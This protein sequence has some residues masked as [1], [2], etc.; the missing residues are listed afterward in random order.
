MDGLGGTAAPRRPSRPRR[1]ARGGSGSPRPRGSRAPR[2]RPASAPRPPRAEP[3]DGPAVS[4]RSWASPIRGESVQGG[5]SR[6]SKRL[7]RRLTV[8]TALLV[9]VLPFAAGAWAVAGSEAARTRS[10]AEAALQDTLRQAATDYRLVLARAARRSQALASSRR[11]QRAFERRDRRALRRLSRPNVRLELGAMLPPVRAATASRSTRIVVGKRRIGTVIVSV[12]FD[13]RLLARLEQAESRPSRELAFAH[14]RRLLLPSGARASLPAALAPDRP[15]GVPLGREH[16][17]AVSAPLSRETPGTRLVALAPA[18]EILGGADATRWRLLLVGLGILVAVALAAYFFAPLLGRNRLARQQRD[19][20]ARVLSHL[21]EG[22]FLVDSGGVIRRLERG[23]RDHHRPG[24][25]GGVRRARRDGATRLGVADRPR[26]DLGGRRDLPAEDDPARAQQPRALAL[27]CRRGVR[28]RHRLRLPRR[29]ERAPAG[30]DPRRVRGHRLA[31]APHSPRGAPRRG[32][33][34]HDARPRAAGGDPRDAA[35]HDQQPVE[36]AREPRRGHP[37]G[38][39]TRRRLP[40]R[41]TGA[42]QRRSGREGR[43]RRGAAARGHEG[44]APHL[45]RRG[46]AARARRR[47]PHAS[48]ARQPHRQRGQVLARRQPR[49]RRRQARARAASAS[50]CA[51]VARGSR[52]PSRSTSS[53]SSTASIPTT[54]T[55]WEAAGS[56]CTSAASSSPPCTDASGSSRRRTTAASSPSS[57]PSRT[58]ARPAAA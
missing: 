54:I 37:P 1:R 53:R 30:G 11:V 9:L 38:G 58:T 10:H 18:A 6:L 24:G 39:A 34:A 14:G 19:Q 7:S 25:P 22:V 46:P 35:G 29:H 23:G 20:A 26:P 5:L 15:T 44:D 21:G 13:R 48:G 40:P 17:V 36:A 2:A 33:H 56:A 16:Y 43:G 4:S 42:V 49:R 57:S 28:R 50:R 41:R 55:A 51:T 52:A 32:A 31:R 3:S 12:P 27:D 45:G 8:G 47:G